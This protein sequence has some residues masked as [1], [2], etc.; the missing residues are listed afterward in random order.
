MP[1]AD[2]MLSLSLTRSTSVSFSVKQPDHA[3]E[4]RQNSHTGAA[5]GTPGDTAATVTIV[6]AV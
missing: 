3:A 1:G 5:H 4:I 6:E 2:P